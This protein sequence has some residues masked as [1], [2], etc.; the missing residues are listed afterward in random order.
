M[1]SGYGRPGLLGL[2]LAGLF[3]ALVLFGLSFFIIGYPTLKLVLFL[4]GL[5]VAIILAVAIILKA[6]A[7]LLSKL[8]K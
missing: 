7:A 5:I 6:L 4:V 2:L 3:A 1:T 8:H